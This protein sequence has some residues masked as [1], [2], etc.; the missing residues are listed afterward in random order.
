M[1]HISIG[2]IAA[3]AV[4]FAACGGS[5]SATPA[6]AAETSTPPAS[7]S[8]SASP[9]PPATAQPAQPEQTAAAIDFEKLIALLPD[10]P[11]GWTR[12]KPKGEQAGTTREI[13]AAEADYEKGE[14]SINLEITDT[15]FDKTYLAPLSF[16][17]ASHY[18]ERHGNGYAKAAPIGG[19]PGCERWDGDAK[20]AEV[21]MVVGNRIIV[22]ARGR[23]V[24]NANASRA[25]VAAV[26]QNKLAAL[27]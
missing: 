24:D 11:S 4:A 3:T 16:T 2:F 1:R 21:T 12:S 13:S 26:D 8:P 19:S 6:A 22:T 25:L 20:F 15:A 27:K 23:N 14:S 10:A 7:A 17:L 9:S 5:K 18:S